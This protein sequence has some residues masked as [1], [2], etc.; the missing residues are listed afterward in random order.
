MLRVMRGLAGEG[1]V[2]LAE[3]VGLLALAIFALGGIEPMVNFGV[4]TGNFV[5]EGIVL[6]GLTTVAA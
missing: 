3:R 5:G 2:V 1:I 4:G 6:A